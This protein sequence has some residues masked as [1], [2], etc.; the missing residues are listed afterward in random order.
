VPAVLLI[1]HAQASYGAH[2]YDVLSDRG[3]EQAEAVHAALSARGVQPDRLVSGSL[4]RQRDTALPWTSQGA[5]LAVDPR[6]DEYDASDLLAAHSDA[7]ASL[8]RGPGEEAP[9]LHSRDFQVILDDALHA[10]I[11]AG[12]DGGAGETWTAFRDRVSAALR[13]VVADLGSGE[14]AI[15]ITSGGVIAACCVLALGVPEHTFVALNHVTVNAGITK[16]V[17]GRRG[18]SL[19]SF[20]EHAHLEGD[21]LVTYR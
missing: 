11:A 19:V 15:V 13:D 7:G 12:A 10:W 20:N 8:E 6:L 9:S 4:R 5:T 21:G 2:D 3:T 1:R 16:I 14:T 17:S 18:V